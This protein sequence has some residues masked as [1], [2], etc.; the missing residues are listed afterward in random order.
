MFGGVFTVVTL[1]RE[2]QMSNR[3][4]YRIKLTDEERGVFRAVIKGKRGR[5]KIAA[6]KVQRA[7]AMLKCDESEDG[8]GLRVENSLNLLSTLNSQPSTLDPPQSA[9]LRFTGDSIYSP[10]VQANS[11]EWT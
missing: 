10:H 8:P 4:I 2:D 9:L 5:M 3:K 11:N 6:W 1:I 7:N